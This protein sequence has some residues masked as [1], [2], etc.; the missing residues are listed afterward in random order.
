MLMFHYEGCGW[1]DIHVFRP[2]IRLVSLDIESQISNLES[3]MSLRGFCN[4]QIEKKNLRSLHYCFKCLQYVVFIRATML[5]N[6]LF[7]KRKNIIINYFIKRFF[8]NAYQILL[9]C[10]LNAHTWTLQP[11]QT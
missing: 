10:T 2:M 5:D 4:H 9:C 6:R 1:L 3:H 11:L 8:V 7:N